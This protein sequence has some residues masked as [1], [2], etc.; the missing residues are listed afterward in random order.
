[1]EQLPD[2]SLWSDERVEAWEASRAAAPADVVAVLAMPDLGL[3][4]PV[5]RNANEINMDRGASL[6]KGTAQ[7]HEIGNVG[8]AGH[9]ERGDRTSFRKIFSKESRS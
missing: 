5:Y 9:R 7:P 8:I 1:M 3:K 2:Q 6:I 4:V